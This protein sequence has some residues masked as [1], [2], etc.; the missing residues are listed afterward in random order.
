MPGPPSPSSLRVRSW[1]RGPLAIGGGLAVLGVTVYIFLVVSARALGPERYGALSAMWALVFLVCG[2]FFLPVEQEVTRA[3]VRLRSNGTGVGPL[4]GRAAG[5]AAGLVMGIAVV[6]LAFEGRLVDDLF[7]G[8]A[9]V[10]VGFLL[11]LAGYATEYLCRGV[12]AGCE[13]FTAYGRILAAEGTVRL[14]AAGILIL[15]GVSTAGPL[16]IVVGLTPFLAVAPAVFA[17][18]DLLGPGPPPPWRELSRSL[19]YLLTGSLLAQV[20]IHAGP[21]AVK[22]LADEQADEVTGRFFAG[23]LLTRAPLFLFLAVQA[24]LLP[25]FASLRAEGRRNELHATVNRLLVGTIALGALSVAAAFLFGHQALSLL[26]GA[27]FKLSRR[28]LALMSASTSAIMVA[29]VVVQALVALERHRDV[30]LSWLC[31]V[32]LFGLLLAAGHDP[33]LR[34]ELGLL[35]GAVAAA[36]AAALLLHMSMREHLD[37]EVVTGPGL[38]AED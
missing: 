21:L 5:A 36:C 29:L 18:R 13:R 23:L 30:A 33:V 22:M 19:T 4:F 35:G 8:Q 24:S 37:G 38:T 28:D 3:V 16:A 7:D 25:R 6:A 17:E 2:G 9:L 31:G 11:S 10:L 12:L 14:V 32:L 27:D 34:V 1:A 15:G 20:L 26:F